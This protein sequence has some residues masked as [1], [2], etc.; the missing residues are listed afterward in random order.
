M[1]IF[2]SYVSLPEGNVVM[3]CHDVLGKWV[4]EM[5]VNNIELHCVLTGMQVYISISKLALLGSP[6]RQ[7]PPVFC[8]GKDMSMLYP[9]NLYSF[10][11]NNPLKFVDF[12][13]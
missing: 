13:P 8:L 10:V 5:L 7:I 12:C 6:N 9:Q 4:V 3:I 11:R 2:H 1:V